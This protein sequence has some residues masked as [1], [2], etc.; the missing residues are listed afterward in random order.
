PDRRPDLLPR[1][2]RPAVEPRRE[3]AQVLPL[4]L[5]PEARQASPSARK[6]VDVY[7]WRETVGE[8]AVPPDRRQLGRPR[9]ARAAC[10]TRWSRSSVLGQRSAARAYASAAA[11]RSPAIRSRYAC[12]ASTL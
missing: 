6:N 12:T 1:R 9:R 11:R 5:P 8:R 4:R 2:Q 7:Y 10:R 3:R